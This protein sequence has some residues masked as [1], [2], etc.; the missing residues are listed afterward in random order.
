MSPRCISAAPPTASTRGSTA[1]PERLA[2]TTIVLPRL[3]TVGFRVV[4]G[5]TRK[6]R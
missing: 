2:T 4:Q 1:A 3:A 5:H 6:V